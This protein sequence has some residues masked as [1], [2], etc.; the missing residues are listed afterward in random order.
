MKKILILLTL[1]FIGSTG[2]TQTKFFNTFTLI[3]NGEGTDVRDN[4]EL[5]IGKSSLSMN[6]KTFTFIDAQ[7]T[8]RNEIYNN[9]KKGDMV[10][11]QYKTNY[12]EI[13]LM[14]YINYPNEVYLKSLT[15]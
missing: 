3:N 6:C 10:A 12:Y 11:A 14:T 4:I 13:V 15:W 2:I 7:K 9:S 1:L 5:T 8:G